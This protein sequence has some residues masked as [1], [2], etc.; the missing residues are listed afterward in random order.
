M[1]ITMSTTNTTNGLSNT[2][3][4]HAAASNSDREERIQPSFEDFTDASRL[5]RTHPLPT[6]LLEELLDLLFPLHCLGCDL[7]GDWFCVT[8]HRASELGTRLDYCQL[9]GRSVDVPG[10]L[11][12]FH[13]QESGLKG[14]ISYGDYHA[15]PLKRAIGLTKYQ[16]IWAGLP[17]LAER[18]WTAR[19]HVLG[20]YKWTAVVPLTLDPHRHRTRGFNQSHYLAD[21]LGQHLQT[22]VQSS[23]HRLRRTAQQVGLNRIDRQRNMDGVFAW[24]GPTL[25]GTVIL[26]DDVITTGATLTSAA[27]ALQTAGAESIWACTLAY[28]TLEHTDLNFLARRDTM[29]ARRRAHA[30]SN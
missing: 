17:S 1:K 24:R 16:G 30:D 13:R 28:E 15:V 5:Q 22:P 20:G 14:L 29:N 4:A 11:C 21:V 12:S 8:C 6:L 9:C 18:A 19:W 25:H 26:V 27:A 3:T 7:P 10:G 23:L 2:E